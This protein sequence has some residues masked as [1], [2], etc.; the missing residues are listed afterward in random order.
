MNRKFRIVPF[1]L[2]L[3]ALVAFV[4]AYAVRASSDDGDSVKIEVSAPEVAGKAGAPGEAKT[5]EISTAKPGERAAPRRPVRPHGFPPSMFG[6]DDPMGLGDDPFEMMRRMQE[7][8]DRLFDDHFRALG[9]TRRGGP[10]QG[11]GPGTG[12]GPGGP[13]AQGFGG[14]GGDLRIDMREEGSDLKILCAMPGV[15]KKS[16]KVAIRDGVF[17]VSAERSADTEEKGENYYRREIRSGAVS[18][19]IP[20]PVTVDEK[21]AKAK[22]EDG[23]LTVTVPKLAQA[24]PDEHLIQV[25]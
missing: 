17:T 24:E 16:I 19:S 7:D 25:E 23:L 6:D 11:G 21:K 20:L 14:F 18:R 1:T 3:C 10:A 15:D 4:S 2:L 9:R 12:S 8:M 13:P 5:P 22:Y